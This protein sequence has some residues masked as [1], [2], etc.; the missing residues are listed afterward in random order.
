[1]N[2]KLKDKAGLLGKVLIKGIWHPNA[3][4]LMYHRV[5]GLQTDPW[6]LCVSP[7]NFYEQ[8]QV[9]KQ[10]EVIPMQQFIANLKA[11]KL[12]RSIVITFD[13]GYQDNF[14]HARPV[15]EEAGLPATFF[16]SSGFT[17]K[18]KEFWCNELDRIFLEPGRLPEKLDI[19]TKNIRL[20]LNLGE[21]SLLTG[22]RLEQYKNWIAW[23]EPPTRRHSLYA[24]ISKLIRPLPQDQQEELLETLYKWSGKEREIR[25]GNLMMNE[26]EIKTLS[27]DR[28]FEIGA[29]TVSHPELSALAAPDQYNEITGNIKFLENIIE[30]PV[31]GMAYPY[32]S[33]NAET[34]REVERSGLQYACTTEQKPVLKGDPLFT[35]PR[36]RVKNWNGAE[37]KKRIDR[38][39]RFGV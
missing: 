15:L 28:L 17:G 7:E 2:N 20:S 30:R 21:D 14:A 29:H 24:E 3:T 22:A 13:D 37:F 32:G 19:N 31:K 34:V 33:Y 23:E 35:L 8:V 12:S 11:N 39:L 27:N 18:Q 9:L 10:Y 6:L 36:L 26:K 4:I 5:A 38:W 25:P 1:M 16:I